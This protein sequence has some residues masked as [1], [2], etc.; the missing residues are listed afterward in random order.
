PVSHSENGL[1]AQLV[2]D[3]E[4]RCESVIGVVDV[5]VGTDAAIAGD[6]HGASAIKVDDIGETAAAFGVD[7]LGEINLP[8]Q[9]VI[10]GQLGCSSKGILPI[11]ERALLSLCWS[12]GEGV[13]DITIEFCDISQQECR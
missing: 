10:D 8:T 5:A 11:E 13:I 12:P 9:A 4:P 3:T 7:C 1:G 2:C 6:P